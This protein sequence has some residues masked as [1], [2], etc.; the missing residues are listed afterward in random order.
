MDQDVAG[1]KVTLSDGRSIHCVNSYE[2][3][4]G[5]HEISSTDLTLRGLT[6]P[7]GTYIDVGANIGLFSIR[8]LDLCPEAR[9]IA[10]EPMSAAFAALERNAADFEG[11]FRAVR[12]ALGDTP[13]TATFEQYPSL[14]CLSTSNHAVGE[15]LADGIRSMLSEKG[16]SADIRA[17]LD[18][19]G[20]YD[21]MEENGFLDHLLRSETVT[22]TVDTLARQAESLGIDRIEL[23]KIDTE[24][25]ERAVMD[26]IGPLWPRIRQLIVEV[27]G[28]AGER[29]AFA[30]E[31]KE[32]GY[33]V[34]G[35]DHPM[36]EGAAPVFYLYA[37]RP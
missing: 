17:M 33:R 37:H 11:D 3:A 30:A 16:S 15:R 26:G 8:L 5:W 34:T 22:A 25:N 10:Y 29:D 32:R 7:P 24:G 4:L 19:T 9:I 18:R 36:A 23:L 31:L 28:G 20:A 6:F 27:H 13:G 2:V 12:L 1:S 35:D 21:R 14:T